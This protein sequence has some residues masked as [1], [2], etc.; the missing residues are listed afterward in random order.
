MS[1]EPKELKSMSSRPERLQTPLKDATK[2]DLQLRVDLRAPLINYPQDCRIATI[3]GLSDTLYEIYGEGARDIE[4]T[5][6]QS[7]DVTGGKEDNPITGS[8]ST[9]PIPGY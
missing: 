1:T 9:T 5:A 7:V 3:S 6:L 8:W 2:E 4:P